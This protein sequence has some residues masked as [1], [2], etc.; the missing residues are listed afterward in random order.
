M[1]KV[2]PLT[3]GQKVIAFIER[4]CLTPEGS[5][6]GKPIVLEP[7][8]KKFI[9]E[10]Y[11][12][13]AG[14]RKAILSLARKNGK[15]ALIA[16]L[17]LCHIIGSEA[18]ENSQIISGAMS[19]EQASLIFNLAVKMLQLNPDLEGLYKVIPSG[20][21][22][23]GLRKN[24]EYKALSSDGSTAHGLSPVLALLDE[25]GQI[26]GSMTPFVEA[27][28]TSQGA[29]ENPLLVM[30]ST[31]APSDS[32]FFSIQID[33]AIRSG[34]PHT[35]CHLYCA[36]PESDLMDEIQWAK[37]NPALGLFRSKKDL[38]E[39]LKQASRVPSMEASARNLLLNQRVA[40][41]SLWLAPNIWKSCSDQAD[42]EVFRSGLPVS[43]GLDLSSRNDLTACV[44][45]CKDDDG[46]IHLLT[47]AFTP[48]DGIKERELLHKAPYTTWVNQ[49]DLIAVPDKTMD[50]EWLCE[51]MKLQL[52]DLGISLS[53][54][55]FDRWRI[56][57][58]QASAERVGFGQEAIW[59]EV[60]QGYRDISP[61]LE[62]F[63]TYLLN[64]KMRHGSHPVLNMGASG[65]I[66]VRDPAG[67]RKIDKSKAGTKID[68]LVASVMAV[69]AFMVVEQTDIDALIG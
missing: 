12:N 69:G 64:G 68:A 44:L 23:H 20:K 48:A 47:Y 40:L 42:I 34:D 5:Q 26:R 58:L 6:V 45:A 46:V 18:V 28:T 8:Q 36:D 32:D 55:E 39:Q 37:A 41:D 22:I 57:E 16:C 65:A 62:A 54:I 52:D 14:T 29:Y 9:L 49:G 3:R 31:Q 50:Y 1:K 25:V 19:R 24:V 30:I 51:F 38:E 7:F 63:E 33:D 56:K 4:Y 35:V 61:R 2:K 53:N 15:S 66:V 59:H 43:M 13:P 11:D 60:G 27:I 17:L 67:N 21:R 10:I